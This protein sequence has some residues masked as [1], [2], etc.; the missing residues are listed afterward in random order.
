MKKINKSKDAFV[1]LIA[2]A[3]ISLLALGSTFLL[4]VSSQKAYTELR[5]TYTEM[6]R[7]IAESGVHISVAAIQRNFDN[8]ADYLNGDSVQVGEGTATIIIEE[9]GDASVSSTNVRYYDLTS[10][11]AYGN[12]TATVKVLLRR[13]SESTDDPTDDPELKLLCEGPVYCGG[14]LDLRNSAVIRVG[15]GSV[16]VGETL[17]L[18][19]KASLLGR[20]V[21]YTCKTLENNK[22]TIEPTKVP[23][24][25]KEIT[26]DMDYMDKNIKSIAEII[27][28]TM[29]ISAQGDIHNTNKV[30]WVDGA[31]TIDAD[32][33]GCIIATGN[34]TI[35]NGHSI[36]SPTGYPALVS[37]K[38]DIEFKH[39]ASVTGLM[40]ASGNIVF[41]NS[42]GISGAVICGG[43]IIMHNSGFIQGGSYPYDKKGGNFI[44]WKTDAVGEP[45]E[46]SSTSSVVEEV[47]VVR[48]FK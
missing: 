44:K 45:P 47:E 6:A 25:A 30:L 34:I 21:T 24:E 32:I 38:G 28:T 42:S 10:T 14:N 23:Y 11:A 40:Y 27:S 39:G 1:L 8:F 48:W 5:R 12:Q 18:K 3:F 15:A 7:I 46:G 37:T 43:D 19:N 20:S 4:K 35:M 16:Y 9:S 22:G 29:K 17:F 26:L 36:T 33:I 13:T 31:V 41:K 2:L